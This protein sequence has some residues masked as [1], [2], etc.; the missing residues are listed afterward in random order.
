MACPSPGRLSCRLP[1]YHLL[2]NVPTPQR[3]SYDITSLSGNILK[4]KL[5]DFGFL[6]IKKSPAA[7]TAGLFS[8]CR[9]FGLF[10]RRHD[11]FGTRLDARRPA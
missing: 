6:L 10:H 7:K 8:D 4:E 5:D 3:L 2:G 11:E 9:I 1:R